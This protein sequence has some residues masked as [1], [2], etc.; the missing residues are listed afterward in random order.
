M[1]S[2]TRKA[3]MDL[4][5]DFYERIGPF[6]NLDHDYSWDGWDRSFV[7]LKNL[8]KNR[9]LQVLDVGC[10]NARLAAYLQKLLPSIEFDKWFYTGTDFSPFLLS[11]AKDLCS[12]RDISHKLLQHDIYKDFP[13]DLDSKKFDLVTA[14]GLFHHLP[15]QNFRNRVFLELAQRLENKGFLVITLW[16][17]W[18]IPRLQ[19]R[20]VDK[21][22]VEYEELA[23]KW[24]FQVDD[25][26]SGD[27]ILNW[28]KYEFGHRFAHQ[29][30]DSEIQS[31][32]KDGGLKLVDDFESDGR[33]ERRNRYLVWQKVS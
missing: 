18:K 26:D 7:N 11:K 14:F 30:D 20:I 28:V 19:K 9:S 12:Q 22:S 23:R 29:F 6:W 1:N 8:E 10:G 31:W 16:Q 3:L 13:S 24:D 17:F 32:T 25:L 21:T 15:D 4:T 5:L 2:K 33:L 27:A